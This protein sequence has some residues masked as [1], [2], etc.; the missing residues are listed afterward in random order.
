MP[1][2]LVI[3]YPATS[4][5]FAFLVFRGVESVFG[6]NQCGTGL[7]RAYGPG[8]P[9]GYTGAGTGVRDCDR[10]ENGQTDTHGIYY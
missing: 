3:L 7:L 4:R 1:R 10:N 5:N 2:P 9:A 6:S 8:N